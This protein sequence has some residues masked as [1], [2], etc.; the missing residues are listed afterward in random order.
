MSSTN[1]RFIVA[2]VVLVGVPLAGLA[3]VLKAGR[4]LSAPISID[5]TWKIEAKASL[6]ASQPCNQAIASLLD[7]PLVV[8]QSGKTLEL[9]FKGGAAK[10]TVPGELEGR[11]IEASLGLA[12]GCPADQPVT[13]TASVD[14][15]AEPKLLT[16]SLSASNCVGCTPVEFRAV[17]QP[18]TQ[19]GGGH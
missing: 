2:Y 11:K 18:K 3:G 1:R 13:L 10:I 6:T 8:S 19:S 17:H 9:T 15:K 4:R 7:S 14:P 16:G 5:G 12:A